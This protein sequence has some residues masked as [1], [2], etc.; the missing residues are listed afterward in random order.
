MKKIM[1]NDRFGLTD[2]VLS[3]QKTMTRRVINGNFDDIKAYSAN[4]NWHFIAD[5][6]DGDSIEL[7]PYY[8]IGDEVAIAQ[9]YSEIPIAH[10]L[11]DLPEEKHWIQEQ[12]VKQSKGYSN[13]MFVCAKLMPHC[14]RITDIKV[15]RLA[16]ISDEDCEREGVIPIT[17]RQWLEQDW[18]DTSPQKYID[19]HLWTLPKFYDGLLDSWADSNPDEYMAS[20][21]KAAFAVLIFKLM[22]KKLWFENPWVFAYS[23]K[24]IK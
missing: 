2:A 13:K 16:D 12:L 11:K 10:F 22:S 23:F 20:S 4:G 14:I 6:K 1:F 21:A 7:K 3:R 17:W 24:L 19:H 15:E 5:T 9:R 8:Q 18:G